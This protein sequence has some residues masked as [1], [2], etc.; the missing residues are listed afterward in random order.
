MPKG[1]KKNWKTS[2]M[3]KLPVAL[4]ES[5]VELEDEDRDMINEYGNS[6]GFLN[7]L[8]LDSTKAPRRRIERR[9][10]I[11][12]FA[13][14]EAVDETDSNEEED[15]EM[16]PRVIVEDSVRLPIRNEKGRMVSEKVAKIKK[17]KT[18]AVEEEEEQLIETVIEAPKISK[19]EAQRAKRVPEVSINE[20]KENLANH[21]SLLLLDPE[22]NV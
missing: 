17:V 5:D 22:Q 1:K 6:L 15:Y 18:V 14:Q 13:V 12:K 2:A 19:K 4:A 20:V 9:P 7:N 8:D 16:K 3:L 11:E 10:Q 21:A